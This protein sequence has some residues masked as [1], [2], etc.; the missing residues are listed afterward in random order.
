MDPPPTLTGAGGRRSIV[1]AGDAHPHLARDIIEGGVRDRVHAVMA[2]G[3]L[4]R[5]LAAGARRIV[6]L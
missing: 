4:E 2:P 6:S 5:I 1:I 3:A